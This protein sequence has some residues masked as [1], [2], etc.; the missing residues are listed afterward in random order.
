MRSSINPTTC[1]WPGGSCH[2]R[3]ADSLDRV[4][5]YPLPLRRVRLLVDQALLR[6]TSRGA[7]ST[8][9]ARE[10]P[11][12][13]TRYVLERKGQRLVLHREDKE[14]TKSNQQ[15]LDYTCLLRAPDADQADRWSWDWRGGRPRH[16]V[17]LSNLTDYCLLMV[18]L[19][20]LLFVPLA[21]YFFL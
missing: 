15:F 13:D 4:R 19:G 1:V 7:G 12:P 3:R 2:E 20:E 21:S 9:V 10:K 14:V 5:R 8:F 11:R 18:R 6:R 16:C 17:A